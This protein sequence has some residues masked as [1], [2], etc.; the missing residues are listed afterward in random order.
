MRG[1]TE[2]IILWH[3]T[4][5]S[6]TNWCLRVMNVVHE[7]H[8]SL[9]NRKSAPISFLPV[10]FIN[11]RISTLWFVVYVCG[12]HIRIRPKNSL[13]YL[14]T[15]LCTSSRVKSLLV[16]SCLYWLHSTINIVQTIR[17]SQVVLMETTR[18]LRKID[19]FRNTV[20][21]VAGTGESN[22]IHKNFLLLY[23]TSRSSGYF[24]Q[25]CVD[26]GKEAINLGAKISH[27]STML[28]EELN[29]WSQKDLKFRPS[30]S[31]LK[32][33]RHCSQRRGWWWEDL[34]ERCIC[35]DWEHNGRWAWPILFPE[36]RQ[37]QQQ[38]TWPRVR[39]K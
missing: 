36:E 12:T 37:K 24:L 2:F 39:Q 26:I 27:I 15:S 17:C 11:N 38:A 25:A 18:W 29:R 3:F 21:P 31:T 16:C 8:R 22:N 14:S 4:S 1:N 9:L 35:Y 28:I 20:Q 13:P 5:S 19:R 34:S 32:W 7:T 10:Q 6:L 30:S 23:N 33:I